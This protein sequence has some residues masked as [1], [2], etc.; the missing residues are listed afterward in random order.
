MTILELTSGTLQ[1]TTL[2]KVGDGCHYDELYL[3]TGT[4]TAAIPY[5]LNSGT[6]IT[7]PGDRSAIITLAP[8][9]STGLFPAMT[10]V[11]GQATDTISDIVLENLTIWGNWDLQTVYHGKGFH[12]ILGLNNCSGVTVRNITAGD[13]KGDIA[14]ITDSTDI[15]FSGNTVLGCGHDGL[16][17]ERCKDV[18]AWNNTIKVRINSGLRSKGSGNVSFHD[19]D[20]VSTSEYTPRTGPLIQVE[21]SKANETTSDVMISNNYLANSQGPGIWAAGHTATDLNA[22]KGLIIKNNLIVGCGQMP[23]DVMVSSVGGGIL[24]DGWN[25]VL[26]ENNTLDGCYGAGIRFAPYLLTSVNSG[27]TA[28]VR[29]NIITNTRKNPAGKGGEA[30]FNGGK[31]V[32]ESSG[33]CYYGNVS[34]NYSNVKSTSDILANPLF[35]DPGTNYHLKEDSPC[36]L[37]G[38]QLGC[39]TD[40]FKHPVTPAYLSFECSEGELNEIKKIYPERKIMRKL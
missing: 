37:S 5:K 1:Q 15:T 36:R 38:G 20:I 25:D 7:G 21:N 39:Y 27:Y 12:N 26:V 23:T 34:E 14:R 11:F 28:V 17:I 13:N 19:N 18:E 10:P 29:K 2:N 6:T 3:S 22:A 40:D 24:V 31:Y 16:Y 30:V 33:N 35:E 32:I 9:L 4:Y 8:G